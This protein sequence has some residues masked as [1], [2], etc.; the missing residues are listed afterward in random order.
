MIVAGSPGSRSI[1]IAVGCAG[2]ASVHWCVCSSSAARLASHT[3]VGDVVDEAALGAAGR[4][5]A[6]RD[7]DPLGMVRRAVLLEEAGPG[8]AVRRPHQRGRPPGEV[9]EHERRDPPVVVDD[10]GFAEPGCRVEHLVEVRERE[11]AALDLDLLAV[12][13]PPRHI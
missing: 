11:L 6:G 2:S 1:T 7:V 12:R 3:S 8:R 10:V 5:V 13:L 4:L 9:G